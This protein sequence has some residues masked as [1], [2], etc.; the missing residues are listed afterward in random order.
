[1]SRKYSNTITKSVGPYTVTL[2]SPDYAVVQFTQAGPHRLPVSQRHWQVKVKTLLG[3]GD[4]NPK[5]AKNIVE[6]RGLSL[7]PHVLGGLGNVCP[8][9][10][11]CVASCLNESGRGTASSVRH[12][13][14]A[15]YALFF[16]AREWFLDKLARELRAFGAGL[17]AGEIGGVRL[18][19]FSDIPWERYG[20]VDACPDNVVLYDYTKSPQ[21]AASQPYDLTYSYD[22]TI[23]SAHHAEQLL[24]HGVNVSVCF[25]E[26]I[27]GTC[28]KGADKQTLP[29][30]FFGVRVIDGTLTDWRPGDDRGVVVGLKLKARRIVDRE[31]AIGSGFS[32]DAVTSAAH[33]PLVG[34]KT[35]T[36]GSI[37]PVALFA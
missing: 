22:G 1:M 34:V 8:H 30:S 3:A 18:N 19:M 14:L 32:V 23:E 21:R 4:A 10:T 2:Y 26:D 17:P 28:G 24:A 16:V 27:P 5:T 29:A 31:A 20:I 35:H 36:G 33:V 7:T 11:T 9:A 6:T 25:H 13:R 12:A 37:R 15:R